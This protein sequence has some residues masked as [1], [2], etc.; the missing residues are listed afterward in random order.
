MSNLP[1]FLFAFNLFISCVKC[2]TFGYALFYSGNVH[3]RAGYSHIH[4]R[5]HCLKKLQRLSA[6]DVCSGKGSEGGR[7]ACCILCRGFSVF[8]GVSYTVCFVEPRQN[9]A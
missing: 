5:S 1:F 3:S 6:A 9:W 4:T 7:R 2:P 8:A